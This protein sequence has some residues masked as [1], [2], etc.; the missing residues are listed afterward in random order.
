M[1][2]MNFSKFLM[3]AAFVATLGLAAIAQVTG[4]AV[5][6][7]V[8]DQNGAVIGGAT[9]VLKDKARGREYTT[10]TTSSG[11]YGFPNV[12]TGEYSI[13]VSASGFG[14]SK[15]DLTV[16]LNQT[17]TAN[18]TLSV[19]ASSAVVNVTGD[20]E[21]IIQTDTSQVGATF[22]DRQFQ[23]LPVSGDP[24]NLALLAPNV[25]SPPIG[26][27]GAGAITGGL[28]QRLNSFTIDGVDNNDVGVS[29]NVRGV[30]TDSVSEFSF[31][32]NN[33]NAEF[34]SGGAG[35]FNTITKSG[36]NSYHGSGFTYIRSQRFDAR[37]TDEISLPNKR[38][39]KDVTYGFTVGGPLP[40]PRFGELDE[41]ESHFA[42]GK[43]H[44]FFFVAAQKDFFKGEGSTNG[45][46]APTAAGL[47]TIAAQPGVS[48]Y[49]IGL[50]QKA[51]PLA[52]AAQFDNCSSAGTGKIMGICGIAEGNVNV[53][54]PNSNTTHAWQV[55]IDHDLNSK[56]QFRYRYY[57][58]DYN[59]AD[60][61]LVPLFASDTKQNQTSFSANWI[62]NV[63]ATLIND[64]RFGY[65]K[66]ATLFNQL[67]DQSQF[68]FP[69]IDLPVFGLSLGPADQQTDSKKTFQY[70][71]S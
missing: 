66:S 48:P 21:T 60:A 65:I 53:A 18:V 63:S 42:S 6:G 11:S 50:V 24:N 59:S 31:L 4:G 16:S 36:T 25:T 71:D 68:N 23:D 61:F 8:V 5:T 69:V 20:T 70:Y 17:A 30:I 43:D 39:F 9:V 22:K 67:H 56:N 2:T 27:S 1:R 40:Y 15:G 64:A 57:R 44:L 54:Q 32:Q 34:A 41:K 19:A 46:I 52:T 10:T 3:I 35:A 14:T 38:F 28:R 51:M 45:Y 55:N 37:S 62:S 49:V 58:Y 33:F 12:E 13:S 26:V 29:G 7:N 47:A